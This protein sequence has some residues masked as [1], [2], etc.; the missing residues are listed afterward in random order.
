M[1]FAVFDT[2]GSA[3]KGD[4]KGCSI[5]T[6][7]E[8]IMTN[9]R[10]EAI[11]ILRRL[12]RQGYTLAAHNAEY[13]IM[14][15]LWPAG[16]RVSIEYYSHKFSVAKW[17][18]DNSSN[19][20]YIYDTLGLSANLSV[21][22]IGQAIGLPKLE[23]PQSLLGIDANQ[24]HWKCDTHDV[25]ECVECYCI[26]DAEIVLKYLDALQEYCQGYGIPLKRKLAGIA[27]AL[28][29]SL[30]KHG[31]VNLPSRIAAEIARE[32]YHGGR[33][34][35]FRYGKVGPVY[36][37]DVSSMYPY[38]MLTMPY[39]DPKQTVEI[40]KG[41]ISNDY[42]S[43]EGASLCTVNVPYSYLPLLPMRYQ[44]KLCFPY[45]T[46]RG[47]FTHAELRAAMQRGAKII[48][49]DRTV[50][51][52]GVV[53]PFTNYVNTVYEQRRIFKEAKDPREQVV[54]VLLN[55]LYGRLGL[56]DKQSFD[57]IEPVPDGKRLSDFPGSF[58][59]VIG[60]RLTIRN[61]KELSRLSPHS[62]VLW[63]SY[64][65]AY[66]RIRLSELMERA[67]GHIIYCDTDSVFTDIPCLDASDGLGGLKYEG[68]YDSGTIIGPK[69]Y[70]LE[71]ESL[72][73]LVR[74]KGV[75]RKFADDYLQ[76]GYAEYSQPGRVIEAFSTNVD[77]AVWRVIHKQ[78]QLI[79]MK[80]QLVNPVG[81]ETG[82]NSDSLPLFFGPDDTIFW[83]S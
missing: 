32:A 75:P 64:V 27:T 78:Q 65:T 21:A 26:R 81:V 15:L 18:F 41:P 82:G 83:E 61:T 24:W 57:Y 60:G 45:G 10:E 46:I 20:V 71:S 73:N 13:D 22:A 56:R 55:A 7:E 39:P 52:R 30:D 53:Y 49:I 2:E 76:N 69:L 31:K 37:Y 54:K 59:D 8:R 44:D 36:V 48:R 50:Y 79:P 62:N 47:T 11:T 38:V 17:F 5:V 25:W 3:A 28:W 68:M 14:V 77:P 6:H 40:L 51:S 16:E 43:Y 29:D 19:Y 4:Y 1:K 23:T 63:A 42:L 80:R 74:A 12:A 67:A 9:E 70:R 33:C 34:E 58:A 35:A 72:G 66:A